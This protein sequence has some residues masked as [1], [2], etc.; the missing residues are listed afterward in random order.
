MES[1]PEDLLMRN[2]IDCRAGS[3]LATP[4]SGQIQEVTE[5]YTGDRKVVAEYSLRIRDFA[6]ADLLVV[7]ASTFTGLW[8]GNA[9]C[10][11]LTPHSTSRE[12]LKYKQL[13][14]HPSSLSGCTNASPPGNQP[15][16]V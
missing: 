16:P 11:P 3:C 4:T 8:A 6:R 10:H 9:D 7:S 12:D 1:R 2:Y 15:G 5:L 14:T 13:S